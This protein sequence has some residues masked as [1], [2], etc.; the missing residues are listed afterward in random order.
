MYRAE[1]GFEIGGLSWEDQIFTTE[2]IILK[3]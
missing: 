2:K 1:L 3:E